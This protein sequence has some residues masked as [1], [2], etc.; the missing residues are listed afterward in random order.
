MVNPSAARIYVDG[1]FDDGAGEE[2]VTV[3]PATGQAI[4]TSRSASPEQVER[5]VAGA[6]RAFDTGA[7]SKVGPA[8]RSALLHRLAD[9]MERDRDLIAELAAHELGTPVTTGGPQHV[10]LP[11]SFLRWF[12]DAAE[13]GPRDGYEEP[14]TMFP[15]PP[16]TTGSMLLREPIGVVAAITAYNVP[17]FMACLKLGGALAAGCSTMPLTSPKSVL[18][19][20]KFV[21]LIDE[22]GFPEG[23]VNFVYGPPSVT[24]QVVSHP[25]V[26]MVSFTGS[27]QVGARISEL[28]AP[29]IKKVVLEL[30]GKLPNI[31][32]PG[33]EVGPTVAAS[34]LRFTRN[35]GQAC[36]ATTR[37]FVPNDKVD[38]FVE[39]SREFLATLPLGDPFDPATLLGPLITAEHRD[40]VEGYLTRAREA[41]GAIPVGGGRPA[42]LDGFF[43]DATLVTGLPNSSE[44]AQEELFAPVGMV[45]GYDTID[46]AIAEANNSRYALNA[47]VWGPIPE[48][49][50]VARRIR[51]GT[52]AVNGGGPM[53]PDAPWG[54]PAFSGIGR[55]GGEEGFREFFEVKHVQW[56]LV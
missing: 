19:S 10:D 46:E 32:L 36:G 54:G 49:V 51:S 26:D 6:R 20:T 18:L 8:E 43:L 4:A 44:I 3:A 34:S 9:L 42:G 50:A 5:A 41:G 38:E 56:P 33:V 48:A 7:W 11:L 47:N 14:M 23:A 55:E 40:R 13:R 22:A 15:G 12:A 37:T 28:A 16:V 27:P 2:I 1:R 45:I 53:R 21:E 25:A 29:T 17:T 39:A 30:G 35:S 31:L 24:E 52:V